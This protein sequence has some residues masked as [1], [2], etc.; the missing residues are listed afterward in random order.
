[1]NATTIL[2]SAAGHLSERAKTYDS[3]E[4]ERSA[5]K[6]AAAF[7][8]VTGHSLTPGDVY[9]LLAVLTLVRARQGEF[10]LDNYEDAAAYAALAGEADSDSPNA[11]TWKRVTIHKAESARGG[12][13]AHDAACEESMRH[14]GK[15]PHYNTDARRFELEVPIPG[16]SGAQLH[17][18]PTLEECVALAVEYCVEKPE[19]EPSTGSMP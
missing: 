10:K 2:D 15:V 3:P 19:P 13:E 12:Y 8:A 11:K 4:G 1:M 6:A 14:F 18:A 17:H 16:D 9:L 7:N 5:A